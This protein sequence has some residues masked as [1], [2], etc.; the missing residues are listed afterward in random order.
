MSEGCEVYAHRPMS[1]FVSAMLDPRPS[2]PG[3]PPDARIPTTDVTTS[4]TPARARILLVLR[5]CK[6]GSDEAP[7][8]LPQTVRLPRPRHLL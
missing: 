7:L 1:V 6:R 3:P 2:A 8:V 4:H 5:G